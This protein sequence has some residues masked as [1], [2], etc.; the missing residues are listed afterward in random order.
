VLDSLITAFDSFLTFVREHACHDLLDPS[1]FVTPEQFAQ[2]RGLDIELYAL[3]QANGLLLP[4]FPGPQNDT[5][6]LFGNFKLPYSEGII[7]RGALASRGTQ[8]VPS[9][10]WMHVMRTLRATAEAMK[11]AAITGQANGAGWISVAQAAQ[12]SG[13]NPGVI[14]RA[15]DAGQLRS[16][17]KKGKGKRKIDALDF[18]RWQLERIK[19]PERAESDEHVASLA[20]KHV[21]K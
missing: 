21:K 9:A 14:S 2:L 16:N 13:I 20:Q 4:D 3:C 10:D 11:R 18:T 17:G 8:L 6:R 19:R 7:H 1:T 5:F 12:I 15:A